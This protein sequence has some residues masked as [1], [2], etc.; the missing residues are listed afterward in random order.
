MISQMSHNV[1]VADGGTGL[2]LVNWST[3]GG[4]LRIAHF[5]GLHGIQIIPLFAWW[6]SKKWNSKNSVKILSVL[7]FGFAYASFIAY[8][9]YQAKQAFPFLALS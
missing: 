9:F 2:P 3:V 7:A 6:I 4:D 1:G 8:T 5:F